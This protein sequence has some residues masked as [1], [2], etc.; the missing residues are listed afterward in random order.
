MSITH[1]W[2]DILD[3]LICEA[4]NAGRVEGDLSGKPDEAVESGLAHIFFYGDTVYKLY[5]TYPDKDHFI[6]GV[7]APTTR[8]KAFLEHDF[9]LNSHFSAE[10]YKKMHSVVYEDGFVT[11]G[12]Y[13]GES[14]Y[15]LIEMSR[16]D[17]DTNLHERLL[18]GSIKNDELFILGHEIAR[19]IDTCPIAAPDDVTWH[20]LASGRVAM[21]RQFVDWLK[22]EYGDRIKAAL[23]LEA[24]EEHLERNKEEYIL[25]SGT[26]LT[27]NV[28]NHDENIF[29]INDRPQF[30]DLLPPM[31][32]WWYGVPYANLANVVANVEAIHSEEAGELVRQG[33][34]DYYKGIEPPQHIYDFTKA[35]AYLISIAHFGSVPGKED[36]AE[37]YLARLPD[38]PS[39]VA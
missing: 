33:Y 8:R 18:K 11:V 24:L 38:I 17:F 2:T 16:L 34:I 28:D 23:V 29:F 10:I 13:D 20:G 5:K 32:A 39:W 25:L 27:V 7:L 15:S 26:M 22:P 3:D 9:T 30:I 37:Q 31:G 35:F 36:V 1:N 19:A 12:P 21:L 14:I 4:L 6:K